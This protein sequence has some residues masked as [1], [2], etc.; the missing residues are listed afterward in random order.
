MTAR[1]IIINKLRKI[2]DLP[3]IYFSFDGH[4]GMEGFR[5]RL[6]AFRDLMYERRNQEIKK[7]AEFQA[8]GN[9]KIYP[10]YGDNFYNE[11]AQ[12]IQTK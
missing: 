8:N 10:Y 3:I 12:A 1:T 6:E 9:R 7:N 2:Y 5:T 11:C 4:S